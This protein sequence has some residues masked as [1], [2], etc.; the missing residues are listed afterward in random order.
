M[1]S[2]FKMTLTSLAGVAALSYS[3]LSFAQA[4]YHTLLV[5]G[6]TRRG[7]MHRTF[8]VERRPGLID[9]LAGELPMT[10]LLRVTT[11]PQLHLVTSGSRKRNAP[12]L[13]G[14]PRMRELISAMRS[15]FEIV[16]VDSPP[17]GAGIDPFVL[18]TVTGNLM[19]VL[20]A[21]ATERDLAEAKLQ[22]V[23]QLPIRLIGAVL[24]DVRATM[25]DYKYY[26][27]SV[28]YGAS[29]EGPDVNQ[30]SASKSVD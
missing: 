12:E 6:D 20:R 28:G 5:D 18:A 15:K 1:N 8:G 29:Q 16:I 25:N 21:G 19:L 22:I 3:A 23:D 10:E 24:N 11:H 27:Y 14:S 7:E 9:Y 13:L 17:L 4:G 26:S 30:L 2:S